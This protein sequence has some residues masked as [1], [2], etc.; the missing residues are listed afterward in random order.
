MYNHCIICRFHVINLKKNQVELPSPNSCPAS[1]GYIVQSYFEHT[2]KASC[3]CFLFF[4]VFPPKDQF[5]N[6]Y[7]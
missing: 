2:M 7:I 5:L 6:K 3:K 1:S 4:D